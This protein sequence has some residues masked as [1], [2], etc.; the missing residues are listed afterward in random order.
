VT[1]K[2]IGALAAG[3]GARVLVDEVYLDMVTTPTRS[4]IH[5][6]DNFVVTTSLTKGYGLSGL[7]CGWILAEA[8]LTE[9]IWQLDDLFNATPVHPGE[10]LSVI[11]LDHLEQIGE[12]ARQLL[13]T[14]RRAL[15]AFLEKAS[16]LEYFKP[17]DGTVI[18]PRLV[19]GDVD[20][21]CE[22]LRSKYETSVVPGKFFEMPDHFRIGLGGDA[23]MTAAGLERLGNALEEYAAR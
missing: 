20:E 5:L 6:A 12:Y 2:R 19:D 4:S 13:A 22:L 17:A 23:E 16:N 9:R 11:A 18:F 1:L 15:D 8:Q 14:N 3:V 7:R 10:L 21:F